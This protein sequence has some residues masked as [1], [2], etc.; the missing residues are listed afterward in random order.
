MN[1]NDVPVKF[2]QNTRVR[3]T[4]GAN[5]GATGTILEE[6]RNGMNN[7]VSFDTGG[8]AWFSDHELEEVLEPAVGDLVKVKAYGRLQAHEGH[9]VSENV[10]TFTVDFGDEKA[11][12]GSTALEVIEK[13]P[14]PRRIE[15][16][17]IQPELVKRGDTISVVIIEDKTEVK[18]TSISE[19][20]VDKIIKKNLGS[21]LEFQTRSGACIHTT[22][23]TDNAVISLV[24]SIDNNA[25]YI[26]LS[27]AK[28]G[29]IIG[30]ADEEG[31]PEVNLAIKQ[32][33]QYWTV[34][35]GNKSK[36]VETVGLVNILAKKGVTFSV[37]RKAEPEFEFPKGTHVKVSRAFSDSLSLGDWKV[38]IED[39][40]NS[41]IKSRGI[42][43][44]TFVVPNRY[45]S[46]G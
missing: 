25:E 15:G 43:A 24:K 29:E 37:V 35:L 8:H 2:K 9:I 12:F 21:S 36:S 44:N 7:H 22:N 19:G 5:F 30:F 32:I 17:E 27:G 4:R 38:I 39:K 40:E 6:R 42:S 26:S 16:K 3:I 45:L 11:A 46:K 34:V 18:R 41:T 33:D 1:P 13:L 20:T 23:R 14:T 28:T 31:G 10:G